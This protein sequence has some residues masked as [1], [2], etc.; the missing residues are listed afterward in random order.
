M[1]SG[2]FERGHVVLPTDCTYFAVPNLPADTYG[3]LWLTTGN[4]ETFEFADIFALPGVSMQVR[5][6]H[7]DFP[8][9]GIVGWL[10]TFLLALLLSLL[11]RFA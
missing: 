6:F 4:P 9:G 10:S 2:P 5:R 8:L 11:A 7:E 1:R 3:E